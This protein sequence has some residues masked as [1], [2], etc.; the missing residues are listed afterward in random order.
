M[1]SFVLLSGE[2]LNALK[3]TQLQILE[4]VKTLQSANPK[5]VVAN[6]VTA[7]EFMSAVRIRRSKFDQL[8][9]GNKIKTVK[10]KRKIYVPVSEIDRYFKDSSIQ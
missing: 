10:K 3:T 4:A 9:A 1:T 8:V 6:H 5:P 7:V 2:E